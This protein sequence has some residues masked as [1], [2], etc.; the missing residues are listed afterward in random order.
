MTFCINM[1]SWKSWSRYH[2]VVTIE[3]DITDNWKIEVLSAK[4]LALDD[5]F[6]DRSLIYTKNIR[7]LKTDIESR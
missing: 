7:G 5:R 2:L 4:S 1:P 6:L 3:T